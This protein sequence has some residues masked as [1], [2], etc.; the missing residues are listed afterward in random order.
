MEDDAL[1]ANYD[2]LTQAEA[3]ALQRELA[4]RVVRE[5]RFGDI[6]LV[7]GLDMAAP[8]NGEIGRGAAVLLRWPDLAVVDIVQ[9]DRRL[10]M[11]YIPG[12]LAFREA[13]VILEAFSKLSARPDLIFLD[14]HGI[15]HPRR[16]GIAAHIGVLLDLPAIGCAKS[17]L[18]GS[19]APL[20]DEVGAHS[21]LCIGDEVVGMALRTR[22]HANPIFVSIGHRVSLA[23]AVRLVELCLRG[24]RLPEPTRLADY[25]SKHPLPSA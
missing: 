19:Y 6:H 9:A 13:P 15:A 23:T 1:N 12:L 16:L 20:P 2:S 25:Y 5:D 14:G 4:R 7:A 22:R 17:V 21:T 8:H 18:R 24:Y 11:D 10:A 3:I